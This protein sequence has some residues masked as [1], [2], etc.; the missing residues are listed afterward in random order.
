MVMRNIR[1]DDE[2]I[3]LSGRDRNKRGRVRE[4][5]ND[6]RAMVVGINMVKRHVKPNP[7]IEEQGGIKEREASIH[8][9]NLSLI[10]PDDKAGRTRIEWRDNST[11]GNKEK[12]RVF[13]RGGK[14]VK[15]AVTIA[16]KD[17]AKDKKAKKTK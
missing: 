5:L 9:S 8:I 3:V 16:V 10:N 2:V 1:R 4:L 14:A 12:V 11:T 6:D 7:Q 13:V 17:N 15:S